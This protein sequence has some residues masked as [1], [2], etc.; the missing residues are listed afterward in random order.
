MYLKYI[1]HYTPN[2]YKCFGGSHNMK[3]KRLYYQVEIHSYMTRKSLH[4]V[5]QW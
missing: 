1:E 4:S 5:Y 2:R 3:I